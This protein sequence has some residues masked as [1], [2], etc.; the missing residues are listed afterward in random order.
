[1]V[2]GSRA[3]IDVNVPFDNE[4]NL[5]IAFNQK[6]NKNTTLGNILPF[7]VGSLGSCHPGN[8]DIP[9]LLGIDGRSWGVFRKKARLA[10]IKGSVS[11]LQS[12]LGGPNVDTEAA[13]SPTRHQEAN[14][15][16]L[17]E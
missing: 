5:E 7:V 14:Q 2:S 1:M 6:F 10:A 4:G 8:Q 12:H 3:L 13:M 17:G 16:N 15:T 11:I 9:F